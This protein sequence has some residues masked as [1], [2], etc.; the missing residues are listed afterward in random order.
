MYLNGN[1]QMKMIVELN[2]TVQHLNQLMQQLIEL[3]QVQDLQY[4]LVLPM[5]IVKI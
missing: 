1:L 3:I 2:C 4:V 5:L